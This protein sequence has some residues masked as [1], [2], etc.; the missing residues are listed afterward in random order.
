[1]ELRGFE[2]PT[3]CMPCMPVSSDGVAL[4]RITAGQRD[5]GVWARRALSA[6][7]WR[8][9]HLV[10]HWCRRLRPRPEL[11]VTEFRLGLPKARQRVRM[12]PLAKSQS[13]RQL[14]VKLAVEDLP[15]LTTPG[16]VPRTLMAAA[17]PTGSRR[18]NRG[19]LKAERGS[20]LGGAAGDGLPEQVRGEPARSTWAK[21]R[22]RPKAELRLRQQR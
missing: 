9:C 3:F 22:Y 20:D 14:A 15:E 17:P 13:A 1:V 10:C 12:P 18:G 11:A 8:R 6:V 5:S 19:G 4:G 7:A 16:T 2:P 21:M